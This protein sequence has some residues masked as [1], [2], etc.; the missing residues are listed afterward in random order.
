MSKEGIRSIA[1]VGTGV[2]LAMTASI[3]SATLKRQKIKIQAI[4]LSQDRPVPGAT[5]IGPEFLPLCDI[6]EVSAKAVIAQTEGTFRLGA[7]YHAGGNAWFVPY[8][9]YGLAESSGNFENAVFAYLRQHPDMTL[10][11]FSVAAQ[12]AYQSKFAIPGRDRSDLGSALSYGVT[13]SCKLYFNYLKQLSRSRGVEYVECTNISMVARDS[14]GFIK[15]VTLDSGHEVEADFWVDCSGDRAVLEAT[16][17]APSDHLVW[18]RVA[19]FEETDAGVGVPASVFTRTSWGWLKAQH[20]PKRVCYELYYDSSG[21]NETSVN[22]YL[23]EKFDVS[24]D[25]VVHTKCELGIARDVWVN[26]CLSV[27]DASSNLGGMVFT[28]LA[29]I[30]SAIIAFV[31]TFPATI[32]SPRCAHYFNE[33][34]NYF[35]E[36]ALDYIS[37]HSMVPEVQASGIVSIDSSKPGEISDEFRTRIALFQRLGKLDERESDAVLDQ[38]WYGM[39]YGVGLHPANPSLAISDVPSERLEAGLEKVGKA[40][41]NIV[42]TMPTHEEFV[43][44]IFGK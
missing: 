8:G 18:D 21:T 24:P 27:G 10:D 31:D 28:E 40:I 9:T 29:L 12:A 41:K 4:E 39:L 22:D 14:A 26:N 3:L 30:Q 35:V 7:T 20:L 32:D 16:K 13:L 1:I 25:L 15:S 34:W 19:Y 17:K 38:Q 2:G 33:Q 23:V 6:L 36:D 5:G 44:R 42:S 11:N 37:L 43:T